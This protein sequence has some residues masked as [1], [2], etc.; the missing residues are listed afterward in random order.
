MQHASSS[1]TN[2]APPTTNWRWRIAQFFEI[3]WWRRYL[4]NKEK[5]AY[6]DW[7]RA[8]WQ[9]FLALA[10]IEPPPAEA[11]VLDAGCGPAG[12]FIVLTTQKVVALDPLLPRY[13]RDLP[14]FS[15][16]DY[17]NVR[18][19][20]QP[21]ENY[22]PESGAPFD[23]VF[24]LNAIN[25]VADLQTAFDRLAALTKPGGTLALSVDAHNFGWLKHIF[26]LAPGDILHPHQLDLAEY[27]AALTARGF[28]V[29]RTVLVKKELIFSYFL[30]VAQR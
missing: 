21:L 11:Q 6:L 27:Q 30:L 9:R 12:I 23:L 2:H 10:G 15:P 17:P 22:F 7:K 19:V 4:S 24:C 1:A 3:R 20:A 5:T 18:F 13:E 16:A 25:H 28:R 29:E 8:Y 14:H 26:R